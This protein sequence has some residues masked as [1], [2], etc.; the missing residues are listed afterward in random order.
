MQIDLIE[1]QNDEEAVAIQ[2]EAE[3]GQVQK[4][5]PVVKKSSKDI[6]MSLEQGW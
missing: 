3:D 5:P 1:K 6:M 2:F 4:S